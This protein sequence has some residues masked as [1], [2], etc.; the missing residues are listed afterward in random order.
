[1][2]FLIDML[3]YEKIWL[4]FGVFASLAYVVYAIDSN[5]VDSLL[6]KLRSVDKET[7]YIYG[8]KRVETGK[9][10]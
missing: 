2:E 8:T 5:R 10:R 9:R 3:N 1:M 4:Y 7:S 6:L